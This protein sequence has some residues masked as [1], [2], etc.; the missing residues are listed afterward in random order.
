MPPEAAAEIMV[1]Q[2][3]YSTRFVNALLIFFSFLAQLLAVR[4]ELRATKQ[5]AARAPR[6]ETLTLIPRPVK[7][8]KLQQEMHLMNDDAKY[9]AFMVNFFFFFFLAKHIVTDPCIL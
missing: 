8:T 7:C 4:Q 9:A 2:G 5:V 1:L 6:D 3:K